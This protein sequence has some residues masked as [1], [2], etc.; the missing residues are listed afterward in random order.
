MQNSVATNSSITKIINTDNLL[1][2]YKKIG[3]W[4]ENSMDEAGEMSGTQSMSEIST[5][6][7]VL[8]QRNK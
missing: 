4:N 5:N 7:T 1:K 3:E 8:N 6:E 2:I